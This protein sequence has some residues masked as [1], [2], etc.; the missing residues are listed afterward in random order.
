ML[1]PRLSTGCDEEL[2][3]EGPSSRRST[4]R[5]SRS[6]CCHDPAVYVFPLQSDD[7]FNAV[8]EYDLFGH[9]GSASRSCG[10]CRYLGGLAMSRLLSRSRR[11]SDEVDAMW[12]R[13]KLTCELD[14]GGARIG[15][16]PATPVVSIAWLATI[17][18]LSFSIL[19]F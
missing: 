12:P 19:S 16:S 15:E 9:D 4:A 6:I 2:R 13:I 1:C 7:S 18:P 17:I 11:L 5:G 14:C 8:T 10:R 3:I